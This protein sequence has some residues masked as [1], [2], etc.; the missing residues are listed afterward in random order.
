MPIYEYLCS[1]CG[2]KHETLR[3][4]SDPPLT[5]CPHC[6]KDALAKQVS[7]AGFQ[8]KGTGWYQTDF[9]SSGGKPKPASDD[10]TSTADAGASAKTEPAAKS[11]PATKA[12]P[13]AAKPAAPAAPS[14]GTPAST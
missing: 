2:R 12:E 10:K 1:A 9:R 7:A 3:K 8:L 11:E 13:S 6:G 14:G 5:E 4:F